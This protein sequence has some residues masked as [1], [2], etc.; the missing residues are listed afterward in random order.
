MDEHKNR[1]FEYLGGSLKASGCSPLQIGGMNDHVHLLAAIPPKYAV[2]EIIRDIK[3]ASSK[4]ISS[5]LP[6]SN[7]FAWQEGFGSFSV[8]ASQIDA[9][10][11]YILDQ[12]KHHTNKSFRDEFIDLLNR[13]E[14][15]FD[16]KYLWR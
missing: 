11:Q 10:T 6:N 3:V 9:V 16:E 1:I 5:T 8:S 7:N 12:E 14:I 13:H 2:S 15:E 4:W